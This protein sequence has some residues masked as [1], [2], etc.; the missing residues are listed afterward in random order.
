VVDGL[1][2]SR[3]NGRAAEHSI[4]RYFSMEGRAR[5]GEALIGKKVGG[6]LCAVTI[7]VVRATEGGGG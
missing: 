6:A 3:R 7:S 5:H 2:G 1:G 4:Y